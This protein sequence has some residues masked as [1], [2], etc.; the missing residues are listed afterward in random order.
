MVISWKPY[1]ETEQWPKGTGHLQK[2]HFS[3]IF[4]T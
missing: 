4:E 1:T 2:T 3:N